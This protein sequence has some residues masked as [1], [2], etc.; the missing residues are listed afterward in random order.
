MALSTT[1]EETL[2]RLDKT[3]RE[4]Y[5]SMKNKERVQAVSYH[6]R[7]IEVKQKQTGENPDIEIA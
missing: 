6:G 1:I 5:C 2:K 4:V 3:D 7:L